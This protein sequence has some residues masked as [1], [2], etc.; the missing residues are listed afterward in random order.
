MRT[1]KTCLAVYTLAVLGTAFAAH[2]QPTS[3]DGQFMMD[4]AA[5]G[6]REMEM[7]RLAAAKAS[8]PE[9]KALAQMLV[10]DHT[11]VNAELSELAGRKK[12]ALPTQPSAEVMAE[13]DQL[14][15]LS[16][17]AFD[18]AYLKAMI[19]GHEKGISLFTG[20][21]TSGADP[22][23]KAWAAKIL[24]KLKTHLG[25]VRELGGGR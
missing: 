21:S 12:V 17:A 19:K 18:D 23:A 11:M 2:A 14:S 25:K 15:K 5:G 4:A 13:Q 1:I 16:G 24:P 22:D 7:S 20:E 10:D 6:M 9:V 8:R 3:A